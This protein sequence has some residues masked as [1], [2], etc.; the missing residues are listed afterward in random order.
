VV[1]VAVVRVVEC[2]E[3]DVLVLLEVVLT[4]AVLVVV[5]TSSRRRPFADR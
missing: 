5:L 1:V 3:F 2:A 4:C